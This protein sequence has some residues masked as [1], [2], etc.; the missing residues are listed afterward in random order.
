MQLSHG[1][2]KLVL[3]ICAR[4]P[5][6]GPPNASRA[7]GL[8]VTLMELQP[9]EKTE[10]NIGGYGT[11]VEQNINLENYLMK[12]NVFSSH[13]ENVRLDSRQ[14]FLMPFFSWMPP[15]MF[16]LKE[17]QRFLAPPEG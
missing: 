14:G 6:T 3:F 17:L 4:Y 11:S 5:V 2:L 15:Q 8:Q 16:F 7:G 10:C 12:R 13:L 9:P 1:P